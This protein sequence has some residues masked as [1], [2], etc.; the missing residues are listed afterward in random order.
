[1]AASMI[2]VPMATLR[3]CTSPTQASLSITITRGHKC[4]AKMSI[5]RKA[6]TSL[7]FFILPGSAPTHPKK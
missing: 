2:S 4:L 5:L 1:M 6:A 7:E 3:S